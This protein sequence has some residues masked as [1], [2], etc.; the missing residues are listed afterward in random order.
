MQY[1]NP[2][3]KKAKS[4]VHHHPVNQE[5]LFNLNKTT[6]GVHTLTGDCFHAREGKISGYE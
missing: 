6:I 5:I 4:S 1:F 2:A 3:S